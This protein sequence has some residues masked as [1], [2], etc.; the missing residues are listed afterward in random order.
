MCHTAAVTFDVLCPVLEDD[1]ISRR[2]DVVWP[3]RSCDLRPLDYYLWGA[4]KH[5]YH[6]DKPQSIDVLEGNI[7]KA[8]G[9]I[10]LYTNDN[11]LKNWSNYVG[12]CMASRG[13][14]L[15]KI[16]FHY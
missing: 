11:M 7:R 14:H 5:K 2:T 1:I 4:V 10:Q 6:T 12:Y 9:E 16:I 13:C 15:N 3:T 8:I